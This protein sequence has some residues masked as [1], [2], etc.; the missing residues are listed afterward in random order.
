MQA[1]V[2]IPVYNEALTLSR[3]VDA[4]LEH[5]GRILLIDDG[6]DDGTR[7]VAEQLADSHGESVACITHGTNAG[8]GAAL[9]SAFGWAHERGFPWVITM[10]CDEQHEPAAIPLFLEAIARDDADIISGSRYLDTSM[11]AVGTAPGERRAINLTLTAEINA[12]LSATLGT[13]I[14][15]AFCGFKAHRVGPTVG[16]GLTERG[17]AFPMQLW[18]RAAGHGLRIR[19]IPVRLIYNDP[20]RTF[21]AGLDDHERRLAHYRSVLHAEFELDRRDG[22]GGEP[23]GE[24]GGER[25]EERGEDHIENPRTEPQSS[26]GF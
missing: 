1:L 15:D 8:Y 13:R 5:A 26:D 11:D 19:E 18:P 3:V 16:L 12:R 9:M 25:G 4:T 2:A 17:Y 21:G 23:G 7:E 24:P 14:T 10:D 22:L 20:N 6:S